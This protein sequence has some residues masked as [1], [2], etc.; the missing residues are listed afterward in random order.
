MLIWCTFWNRIKDHAASLVTDAA[1][2]GAAER[3]P[4]DTPDTKEAYLIREIFDSKSLF[5]LS[6]AF[7]LAFQLVA[8]LPLLAPNPPIVLLFLFLLHVIGARP[9]LLYY[10]GS[11]NRVPGPGPGLRFSH[12][13]NCWTV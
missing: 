2:A 6:F 11:S 13:S 10:S 5:F 7:R 12:F 8:A 4:T 9:Q 1:M 3:W